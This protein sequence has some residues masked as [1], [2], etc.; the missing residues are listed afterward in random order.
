MPDTIGS[1]VW[2]VGGG[3][4]V[5]LLGIIGFFLVQWITRHDNKADDTTRLLSQ[6][7]K[8]IAVIK[9]DQANL[10]SKI[11]GVVSSLDAHIRNEEVFWTSNATEHTNILVALAT[12]G[13]AVKPAPKGRGTK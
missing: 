10:I 13:K 5:I 12:G 2:L 11:D 8:D 1:L 9:N 6:H 3:I 4:F 7:D